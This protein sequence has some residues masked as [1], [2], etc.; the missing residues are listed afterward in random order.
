MKLKSSN[1][2]ILVPRL[3]VANNFYSRLVG[4]LNHNQ[5]ADDSGLLLTKCTQVHTL[6][7]RF[8]I[9]VVFLGKANEILGFES[10]KPW[11]I[12]KLYFK[13]KSALEKPYGKA[14]KLGLTQ[15]QILEVCDV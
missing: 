6:F 7:M 1:G 8:P 5:L 12:S 11:R 2:Q 9:D 15:G 10:L 4:L 13:A 14:S 3:T